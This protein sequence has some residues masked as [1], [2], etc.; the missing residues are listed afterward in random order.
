MPLDLVLLPLRR[1]RIK[2]LAILDVPPEDEVRVERVAEYVANEPGVDVVEDAGKAQGNHHAFY[3]G[4]V[5]FP[6]TDW[7]GGCDHCNHVE[8]H[9]RA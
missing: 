2:L 7:G 9:T 3:A 1:E 4:V 6:E 5:P 8:H